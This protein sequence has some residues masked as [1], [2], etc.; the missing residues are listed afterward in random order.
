MRRRSNLR[1]DSN[2]DEGVLPI[3]VF[4]HCLEGEDISYN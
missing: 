4:A 2:L 1:I 3:G